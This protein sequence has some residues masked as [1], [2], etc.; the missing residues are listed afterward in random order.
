MILGPGHRVFLVEKEGGREGAT[1]GERG[2]DE[3]KNELGLFL[4][5][6]HA[7]PEPWPRART[8]TAHAKKKKKKE[9][10]EE[11]EANKQ[12]QEG[13]LDPATTLSPDFLK[14]AEFRTARK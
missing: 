6:Q 10:E 4:L 1:A 3:S 2:S 12:V 5:P 8:R 9:E 11:E 7:L 14:G 13:D